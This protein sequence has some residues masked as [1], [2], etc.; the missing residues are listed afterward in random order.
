MSDN[1]EHYGPRPNPHIFNGAR[2]TREEVIDAG[3]G[4]APGV[5]PE[6]VPPDAVGT[7][8]VLDMDS[9]NAIARD[10]LMK[11]I[12]DHNRQ[13]TARMS[14][15]AFLIGL[16][17]PEDAIH[18]YMMGLLKLALAHAGA[19]PDQITDEVISLLLEVLTVGMQAGVVLKS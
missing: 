8:I 4:I 18:D 9:M 3:L 1:R 12:A 6:N 7:A 10:L 16:G 19:T 17:V 15:A 14:D 2:L 5:D 11:L 13:A